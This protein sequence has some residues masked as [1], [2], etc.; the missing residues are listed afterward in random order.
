M[1]MMFFTWKGIH[2][3]F[4]SFLFEIMIAPSISFNCYE[5]YPTF[6]V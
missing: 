4:I 2:L 5:V 1:L 3:K 6:Y